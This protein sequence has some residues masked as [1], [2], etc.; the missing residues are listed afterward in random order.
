MA[1]KQKSS[2]FTFF[3]IG[4]SVLVI[5]LVSVISKYRT[6]LTQHAAANGNVT[7]DYSTTIQKIDPKAYGLDISGYFTPVAFGND[8]VEQ[9]KIKKLGIGYAR[10]HLIYQ[11]SGDPTSKI[12]CGGGGCNTGIT[13]DQWI[14]S[15]KNIGAEPIVIV[16]TKS[17]VDAANMVKHFN[18]DT[19]N[20]IKYWIIGNEPDINGYSV[21]SYSTYFNQD[22]DAMKAID[23]SIKIG[24]GTTSWYQQ[25]WLQQFLQLSGTRVDF[26]DFHGYPQQGTVAGDPV[27]LF[28]NADGYGKDVTKLLGVI[29]STVPSRAAQIPVE[30]GEWELNWGGGAQDYLN[31]HSV[32]AATSFGGILQAGGYSMFYADKGNLL[33]NS[34]HTFIDSTG[35]S[36][37]V[38]QDDTN[39]AY[40]GIGM[41]TGEGLFQHFGDTMVSAT[42]ALPNIEVFASDNPK[43]IVVINKDATIPQTANIAFN[44][45]QS[46][47]FDVWRKDESIIPINPPTKIG[48]VS[49]QN[50][51][52]TYQIPPMSVTTFV[53]TSSTS[54]STTP[55]ISETVVPSQMSSV[56]PTISPTIG[57]NDKVFSITVCPHG[58][59]ICGDNV[60]A[61]GGGNEAPQHTT[62]MASINTLDANNNVIASAEG[63]LVY[64][65]SAKN[66]Q[67]T[68]VLRNLVQGQ[69]LTKVTVPGFLP[70]QFPGFINITATQGVTLPN[71]SLVTGDTNSDGQLDISDYNIIISCYGSKA[72]TSSCINKQAADINDDGVADGIDYNLFLRELSIQKGG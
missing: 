36:F 37:S 11:T 29:K 56:T 34:S 9:Q 70:K 7:I 52:L 43:N 47:T 8:T 55:G 1:K 5:I 28:Q 51:L 13:G 32:W 27:K 62:R 22:Y 58:L 54:I 4:V 61:N 25:T 49:V 66:F 17:A 10:M 20:P 19:N 44:G 15:I 23:P 30:V 72:N 26:L 60:N 46:G 41:F 21:Q 12:I 33:Y 2:N 63:T 18:K 6:N 65:Q 45:L 57:P 68:V 31:F 53:L 50:G 40:H 38:V 59:G 42:T 69:Y 64:N 35:R 48:S 39:A 71:I 3:I 24:G 14:T 16:Y 67:G